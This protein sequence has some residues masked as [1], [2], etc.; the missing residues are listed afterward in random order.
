MT[1]E[2]TKVGG[3]DFFHIDKCRATPIDE[4]INQEIILIENGCLQDA[5]SEPLLS[6]APTLDPTGKVLKYK[7]FGF[8]VPDSD[9]IELS[10]QMVCNLKFG[11]PPADCTGL[12]GGSGRRSLARPRQVDNDKIEQV[13]IGKV[14][15]H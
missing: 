11:T 8:V 5:S 2:F 13:N 10:F 14:T 4:S 15:S 9:P 6:I 1:I 12:T 3:L 7:Q